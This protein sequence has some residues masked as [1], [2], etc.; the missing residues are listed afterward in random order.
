MI[1]DNIIGQS[2][3]NT[4]IELDKRIAKERSK[5]VRAVSNWFKGQPRQKNI[6]N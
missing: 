6:K 1:L 2:T 4:L 3:T 5:R